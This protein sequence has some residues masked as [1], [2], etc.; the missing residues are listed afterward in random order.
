MS[1]MAQTSTVVLIS[2]WSQWKGKKFAKAPGPFFKRFL[3]HCGDLVVHGW[4][5]K[6]HEDIGS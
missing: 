5:F 1:G 6:V 2:E 4:Q 3:N